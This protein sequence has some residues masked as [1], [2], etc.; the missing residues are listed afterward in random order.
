MTQ[1]Q[2]VLGLF[3]RKSN[4]SKKLVLLFHC[5]LFFII[6]NSLKA[7]ISLLI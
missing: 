6:Q 7:H 4:Y 2:S 5:P 3:N 1:K